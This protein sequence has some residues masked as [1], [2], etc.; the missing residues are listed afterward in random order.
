MLLARGRGEGIMAEKYSMAASTAFYSE[1]RA[2]GFSVGAPG[3]VTAAAGHIDAGL[4]MGIPTVP[5]QTTDPC[6]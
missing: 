6:V 5:A 3:L 4:G 1:S 2:L